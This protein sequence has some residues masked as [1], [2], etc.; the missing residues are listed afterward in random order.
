MR[1]Y[2]PNIK[3]GAVPK[4][5]RILPKAPPKVLGRCSTNSNEDKKEDAGAMITNPIMRDLFQAAH[6]LTFEVNNKTVWEKVKKG[7][8]DAIKDSPFV[9]GVSIQCDRNTNPASTIRNNLIGLRISYFDHCLNRRDSIEFS[10]PL[11]I[12][13]D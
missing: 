11:K 2:I 4:P 13:E 10:I 8:Y 7:I 5:N 9:S 1:N 3:N 12:T 6:S